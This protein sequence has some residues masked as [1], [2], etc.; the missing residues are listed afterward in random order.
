MRGTD[1]VVL[2]VPI[3]HLKSQS[4]EIQKLATASSNED[5]LILI[6]WAESLLKLRLSTKSRAL[7]TREA[8]MSSFQIKRLRPMIKLVAGLIK[9]HGWDQRSKRSRLGIAVSAATVTL[10]GGQSAG[11]AALGSAI[12]APLW[13]VFGSGAMFA[14]T[15]IRECQTELKRRQADHSDVETGDLIEGTYTV[16]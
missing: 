15:I 10:F 7:K 12:G 14:E 8:I 1:I 5:I 11:I 16:K 4:L 9:K 2:T 3:A 6:S 13:V